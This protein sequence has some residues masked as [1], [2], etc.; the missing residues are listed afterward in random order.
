MKITVFNTKLYDQRFFIQANQGDQHKLKFLESPLKENTAV[1]AKGSE[2]VCVFVNDTINDAVIRT[3]AEN[4]VKLIALRASGFNNV[5]ILSAYRHGLTVVRVPAYSPYAVAEH[6]IA[7][8]LT[9]NR[10][11]H[12]A[13]NRVREGNFELDGLL[14]FDL[15]GKT[16]GLVGTGR[17]GTDLARIL[18]GMGMRVVATDPYPNDECRKLGVEYAELPVLLEHANIICLTCPLTKQTHHL[19]NRANIE[20]MKSDVM[21]INTGRGA[22]IN[23][24][25]VVDGLKSG[26]IGYLGLDVYEEEAGLFFENHWGEIIQDDIFA[27]LFSFPNVLIT[28]HQAFFTEE[29]LANIARTTLDN[30]TSFERGSG[31]MHKVTVEMAG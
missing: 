16:A 14:G 9:L 29:A 18:M 13:Y 15:F 30:C 7:M 24:Q 23:T 25:D 6:T 31:D 4:G 20:R 28:G 10:K 21:I 5:D 26:K 12:R 22:L 17:I 27:R 8:I 1:L 2:A 3:L 11:T 19:V